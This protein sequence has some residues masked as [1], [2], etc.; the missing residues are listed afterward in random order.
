MECKQRTPDAA[1]LPA[2]EMLGPFVAEQ[3]ALEA[4]LQGNAEPAPQPAPREEDG[5]LVRLA[6]LPMASWCASVLLDLP[7]GAMLASFVLAT[8]IAVILAIRR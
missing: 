6:F 5:R 8:T 3:Q 7:S 1:I 2:N 4:L